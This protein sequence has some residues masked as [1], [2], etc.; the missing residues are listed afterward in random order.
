MTQSR[1]A[2]T[3]PTLDAHLSPDIVVQICEIYHKTCMQPIFDIIQQPTLKLLID[4]YDNTIHPT[5]TLIRKDIIEELKY[6][7]PNMSVK[8]RVDE[9]YL[10]FFMDLKIP[11]REHRVVGATTSDD[12][13]IGLNTFNNR[14]EIV[15]PTTL[16]EHIVL[17]QYNCI[18][19]SY[20]FFQGTF[21]L[22]DGVF[23]VHTIASNN[24]EFLYNIHDSI[25]HLPKYYGIKKFKCLDSIE[26]HKKTT[27]I[28]VVNEV[29]W[30]DVYENLETHF[31]SIIQNHLYESYYDDIESHYEDYD[32]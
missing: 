5:N 22:D 32:W 6:I 2:I 17:Y 19:F 20:F 15:A 16:R 14:S 24:T 28:P 21:S 23:T 18:S 26:H 3:I 11:T 1:A 10:V 12:N 29:W 9:D 13:L 31:G 25:V 7:Y 4:G 8:A 27:T 30:N